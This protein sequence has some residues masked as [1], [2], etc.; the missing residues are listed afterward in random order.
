MENS[1]ASMNNQAH[2]VSLDKAEGGLRIRDIRKQSRPD[3]PLISIITVVFNG[4]ATLEDTIRSVLQ[5]TYDN[6]EYII[7]DGMSRDN[8]LD[9]IRK[10]DQRVDYWLSERDEGIYDAMNK[11]VAIASGEVVGFLNADDFYAD[12][13]VLEQVANVFQNGAIEACYADLVYVSQDGHRVLRYWKSK[14]FTKGLFALGWCPAHPTF[15]VRR[16]VVER[17]GNFD[18]SF[19]FAADAELLMRYL[20]RGEIRTTYIPQVWVRMRVGGQT[21]QSWKNIVQQNKEIMISLEKNEIP[22]SR[23]LFVISKIINRIFQFITG[24]IWRHQ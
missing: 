6:I 13:S 20:E 14:A 12:N 23:I 7:I 3:K 5:Q 10:Y 21:N 19:K 2:T 15:Y 1:S 8:T 22:F 24:R 9:I 16:A 18:K 11:G 17:Y 4:A